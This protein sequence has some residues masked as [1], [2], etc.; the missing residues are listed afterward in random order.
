MTFD[1]FCKAKRNNADL[2]LALLNEYPQTALLLLA[3]CKLT[4]HLSLT[5]E[6]VKASTLPT[7][8]RGEG[9]MKASPSQPPQ[10]E[11]NE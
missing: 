7:S 5:L 10:G 4:R 9:L 2:T 6:R 3:G 11:E 8:P 1:T